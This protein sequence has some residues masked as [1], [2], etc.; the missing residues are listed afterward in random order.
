[1]VK[2]GPR[3]MSIRQGLTPHQLSRANTRPTVLRLSNDP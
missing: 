3:Q 1:M 2:G